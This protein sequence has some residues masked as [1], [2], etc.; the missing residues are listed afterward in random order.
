MIFRNK[1]F[2]GQISLLIKG[3][4]SLKIIDEPY[5]NK[6]VPISWDG[7]FTFMGVNRVRQDTSRNR[8]WL[9]KTTDISTNEYNLIKYNK[10]KIS[11][12]GYF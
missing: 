12:A 2:C 7:K 3:I 11:N 10:R 8:I 6:F 5:H 9:W 4:F 1:Y